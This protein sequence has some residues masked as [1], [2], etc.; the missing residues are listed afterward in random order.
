MD[1]DDTIVFFL[2]ATYIPEVCKSSHPLCLPWKLL[3]RPFHP[4]LHR[5][6]QPLLLQRH[7]AF[8]DLPYLLKVF[9]FLVHAVYTVIECHV[10][11]AQQVL[12]GGA[13]GFA[14]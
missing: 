13:S 1:L 6:S 3:R 8:A 12:L 2:Y 10:L 4:H 9:A 11:V 7:A 14:E 5:Y